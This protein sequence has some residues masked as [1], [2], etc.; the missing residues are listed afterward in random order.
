[1]ARDPAAGCG[2]GALNSCDGFD[3][4]QSLHAALVADGAVV[5]LTTVYRM[6]RLLEATGHVDVVRDSDGERLY[7]PRPDD[8]HGHYASAGSADSD[9]RSTPD[10]RTVGGRDHA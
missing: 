3:S 2:T 6:L 9:W 10:G 1:M 4:A 5:E 8:G 7:R